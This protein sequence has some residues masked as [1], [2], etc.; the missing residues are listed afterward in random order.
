MIAA[1]EHFTGERVLGDGRGSALL[2]YRWKVFGTARANLSG[3]FCLTNFRMVFTASKNVLGEMPPSALG[4]S[5]SIFL[6]TITGLT[7]TPKKPEKRP[8]AAHFTLQGGANQPVSFYVRDIPHLLTTF[9]AVQAA[10]TPADVSRILDEVIPRA[11]QVLGCAP[12]SSLG[13]PIRSRD[14]LSRWAGQSHVSLETA[15]TLTQ[16]TLSSL[17]RLVSVSRESRQ[18]APAPPPGWYPSPEGLH[19]ERWWDGTQWTARTRA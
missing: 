7:N 1:H 11:P 8:N 16:V 12:L 10:V 5:F 9:E 3:R 6:P 14:E 17:A 18:Q 2:R 13:E 19:T 15:D 4:R